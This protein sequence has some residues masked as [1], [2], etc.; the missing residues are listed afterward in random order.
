MKGKNIAIITGASSGI[1][2]EFLKLLLKEDGLDELWAIGRDE[3]RLKEVKEDD[4]ERIR[5]FPMDLSERK[6]LDILDA[7]AESEE[8]NVRWLVNCA[9]YAK[10]CDY[11]GI[12]RYTSVNMIDVNVSALVAMC[13]IFIPH[14]QR[15]GHILNMASPAGFQPLPYQNIYSCTKAF[16]RNYTRALN[17]ELK[18]KGVT[19]TAVCPGWMQ[20]RL[21][22]R[23][24][25]EGEKGTRVFPHIVYPDA[26]AKKAV[27]DAKKSKDQSIYSAYVNMSHAV[28]KFLPQ[29]CMMGIWLRQQ[30]LKDGKR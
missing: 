2:R 6:N 3:Q 29:K 7:L 28:A 18:S 9:G 21:I 25:V 4:R 8:V 13:V 12:D 26:V 1:G 14:M 30:K 24:I 20:T 22:E 16:V 19:A 11:G 15:G 27:K 5:V 17:V 23:A 10:F